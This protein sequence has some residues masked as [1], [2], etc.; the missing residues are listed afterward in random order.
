MVSMN[1]VFLGGNLTRDPELRFTPSGMAVTDIR[2]AINHIY[3]DKNNKKQEEVTFGDVVVWGKQAE[4]LCQYM[5][6]GSPILVEGALQFESWEQDGQKRSKIK[7]R[8]SRI[9][10]LSQG[11]KSSSS[12]VVPEEEPSVAQDISGDI[13]F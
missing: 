2:I 10:F 9:Q 3:M 12:E 4:T 5:K 11:G 7:V 13:P 1:R 8:A 6:K